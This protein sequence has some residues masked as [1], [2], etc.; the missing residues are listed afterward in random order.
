MLDLSDL[1]L[2]LSS[3]FGTI[4]S[5]FSLF[6]IWSYTSHFLSCIESA[7]GENSHLRQLNYQKKIKHDFQLQMNVLFF[8]STLFPPMN[9][10]QP[11]S[12]GDRTFFS[13]SKY[14]TMYYRLFYLVVFLVTEIFK[15]NKKQEFLMIFRLRF[16]THCEFYI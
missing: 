4:N 5:F 15:I 12:H 11:F 10:C 3:Q 8:I 14:N 1:F 7:K 9:P 13:Q 2:L 16:F 6:S